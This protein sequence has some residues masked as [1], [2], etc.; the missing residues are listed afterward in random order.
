MSSHNAKDKPGD[1]TRAATDQ[2]RQEQEGLRG[3]TT[4]KKY[5]FLIGIIVMKSSIHSSPAR[6]DQE[7]LLIANGPKLKLEIV[8][9]LAQ[10][11]RIIALD[12]AVKTLLNRYNKVIYPNVILGDFD[13]SKAKHRKQFPNAQV[14]RI[15]D[16]DTT[17]L[18]KG[19]R[20]CQ[21]FNAPV[22]WIVNALGSSRLDHVLA[23][24]EFLKQYSSPGT[25][26]KLVG[27]SQIIEYVSD[28]KVEFQ[29]QIGQPAGIFGAPMAV[30]TSEG[31]Q[32]PLSETQI[33]FGRMRS[34]S[35]YVKSK[36]VRITVRGQ[37]LVVY[38]HLFGD[39]LKNSPDRQ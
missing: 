10:G 38:P 6:A 20:Y 37:A 28:R 17:D 7:C 34:S 12:G 11:K 19:I 36:G 18:E 35:N 3:M 22:I 14:L 33:D 26:I 23:N 27:K 39:N 9:Q 1:L 31:L 2:L 5:F 13:S 32:Y 4:F 15:E 25:E 29:A 8:K 24:I 16:Q 21:K 30:V